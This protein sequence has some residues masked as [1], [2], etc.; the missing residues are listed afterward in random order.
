MPT[1]TENGTRPNRCADDSRNSEKGHQAVGEIFDFVLR[2][3]RKDGRDLIHGEVREHLR[4]DV[5]RKTLPDS[6][7]G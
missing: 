5:D 4:V 7:L 1:R 6:V 2:Q 3:T